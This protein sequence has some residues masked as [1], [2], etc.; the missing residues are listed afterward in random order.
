MTRNKEKIAV[1]ISVAAME[2]NSIWSSGLYQNVAFL[3][4]LL[5]R[6]PRVGRVFLIN[7]GPADQFPPGMGFDALDVPLVRAGDVTHEVDLVI[8]MGTNLSLEW[9]RHVRALGTR[10]VTFFVGNTYTG[11]AEG[12]VFGRDGGT[13]FVGTP[14]HEIWTLPQ[15]EKTAVPLLRTVGRVPV[16]MLPHIWAPLFLERQ[17]RDLA[18]KGLDFGFKAT[19]ARAWRAG[20]FEP[21]ISVSKNCFIPML[22]CDRAYRAKPESIGL[23]MVM[24]S[25]HM[26]E[27]F[28]FN[29]MA[30]HL[31]ITRAGK[32]S[33]EPR[34]A[35]AECMAVHK[36]DAVVAHQWENPQNYL[37]YDALYGGYPLVHNSDYLLRAGVGFYYPGFAAVEAG[38]AFVKAWENEPSFWDDYARRAADYLKTVAPDHEANVSE[39]A[40]RIDALFGEAQ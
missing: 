28:T 9:L 3:V 29:R 24:N 37:Y 26:K 21:N 4:L 6:I 22:A 23:M 16:H 36:L 35:F 1:G 14:W 2:G 30:A 34:I 12:P 32:S 39:F 5:R 18:A 38:D 15:Y 20:I 7:G 13:V 19:P 31:D 17:V 33:F 27:H 25:V 40:A 8:E 10:I 11:Q